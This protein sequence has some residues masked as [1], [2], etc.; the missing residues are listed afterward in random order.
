ML[1][2]VNGA[3]DETEIKDALIEYK[4]NIRTLWARIFSSNNDQLEQLISQL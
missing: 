4:K 2:K 3:K 1:Y